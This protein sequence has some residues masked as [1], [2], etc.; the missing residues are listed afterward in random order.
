VIIY[1]VYYD[2]PGSDH[3]SHASLNAEWIIIKNTR[4][5][6]VALNGRDEVRRLFVVLPRQGLQVLLS[7]L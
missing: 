4:S 7:N 5:T 2:S 6:T 3:G 1:E